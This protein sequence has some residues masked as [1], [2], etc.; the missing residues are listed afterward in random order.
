[1]HKRSALL[2]VSH[3]VKHPAFESIHGKGFAGVC[4]IRLLADYCTTVKVIFKTFG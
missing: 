2:T 4:S 1:M 3:R